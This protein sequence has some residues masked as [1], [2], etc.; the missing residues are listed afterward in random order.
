MD[1][2]NPYLP[3]DLVKEILLTSGKT[4]II[5][6]QDY[7]P[8][9]LGFIQLNT[10]E[11]ELIEK[12]NYFEIKDVSN[13]CDL[14]F[15]KLKYMP[16]LTSLNLSFHNYITDEELRSL[17]LIDLKSLKLSRN[18]RITDYGLKYISNLTN[19]DLQ[20]NYNITIN[21]IKHMKNLTDIDLSNNNKITI[22]ELQC[23]PNL[24]NIKN[25]H[26]YNNLDLDFDFYFEHLLFR[27]VYEN[28]DLSYSN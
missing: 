22:D 28:L 3:D 1:D 17:N 11:F 25:N 14:T 13:I 2:Y 21:G 4:E 19:I 7:Y 12:Y 18:I 23:F 6:M 5:E 24:V 9:L 16:N 27:I 15:E 8:E 26:S 10:S 20:Y